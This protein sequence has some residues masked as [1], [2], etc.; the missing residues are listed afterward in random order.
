MSDTAPH[1]PKL[2]LI[3]AG[4]VCLPAAAALAQPGPQPGPGGNPRFVD[5]PL[6]RS[7]PPPSRDISDQDHA[8][9][10]IQSGENRRFEELLGN[11]RR[12]GRG[13][14]IGVEPDISTN[15]YRFK[16]MRPTGN[17][18]WVDVDGRTGRVVAERE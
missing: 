16:F 8:R 12:V 9:S 15:I 6:M 3:L 2:P 10:R 18:I 5:R 11:A 17:M 14:Y 1:T 4:L 13:E 7:F